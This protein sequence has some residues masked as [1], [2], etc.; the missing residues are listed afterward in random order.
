MINKIKKFSI[1]KIQDERGDLCFATSRTELIPF[2]IK[3]IYYLFNNTGKHRGGHAHRELEQ[4]MIAISG[5]FEV[6]FDDGKTKK[7]FFL[8]KPSEGIFIPKM[9]WREL[10]SFSKDS[11][12]LVLAS[13]DYKESDYYRNYEEFLREVL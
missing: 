12:C 10:H 1:Q 13:E 8:N 6:H 2:E 3:R 11:V 9:I 5:S 7:S 4:V